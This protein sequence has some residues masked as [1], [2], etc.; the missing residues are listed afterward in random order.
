MYSVN[1]DLTIN[2][3]LEKYIHVTN[4]NPLARHGYVI[5]I[6]LHNM[7][8]IFLFMN[9]NVDFRNMLKIQKI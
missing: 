4:S 7:I 2:T 3:M 9:E 6:I 5:Y 8:H 1:E